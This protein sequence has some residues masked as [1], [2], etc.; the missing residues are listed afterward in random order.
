MCGGSGQAVCDLRNETT[1]AGSLA[2][3]TSA[4]DGSLL[5]R[6]RSDGI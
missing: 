6:K 5:S 1:A 3:Y 4:T 2:A